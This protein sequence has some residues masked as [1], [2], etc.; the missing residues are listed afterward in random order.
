MK[1][2]PHKFLRHLFSLHGSVAPRIV[3]RVLFFTAWAT[4]ILLVDRFVRPVGLPSTVHT[5]V[6]VAL[7]LLLVFRTNASYE[8]FWEGR[9]L[10]GG[11]VNESRNLAR[12]ASAN[13]RER[14]A[15]LEPIINW[16]AAFSYASMHS[17]R[18]AA[19]LG[20]S[21][22]RL[23]GPEVAETLAARHV[24]MAVAQRISDRLV[25]VRAAGH[26]TDYVMVAI[27]ANVQQL[28]D[29]LGACERI[30]KTPLPF[31]YVVHLRR[32][33]VLYCLTVPFA[34]VEPFGWSTVI[35][36]LMIAYILFGIEEIGVEIENPFGTDYN[37]LPLEEICGTIERDLVAILEQNRAAGLVSK[38][39]G[40]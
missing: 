7:G 18:S 12:M 29:Y 33:L 8:R 5:L 17:L 31:A 36:A 35:Y 20:P 21:E 3:W 38:A 14:P 34:L 26:L 11:I 27:D 32:A 19:G 40:A 39:T 28:V 24:P 37:D 13:L 30:Q 15:V 16:A 9:R 25:E 1:Y 23:P 2:D 4:A 6:G 22:S 10:W